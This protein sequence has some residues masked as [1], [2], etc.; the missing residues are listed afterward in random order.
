MPGLE[1]ILHRNR[2]R[3]TGGVDSRIMP[4]CNVVRLLFVS[5]H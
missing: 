4:G 3:R 2:R 1:P 5:Q